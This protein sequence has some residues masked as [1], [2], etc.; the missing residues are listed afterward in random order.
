MK[1]LTG[2]QEIAKAI[3]FGKYP[4]LTIN[5]ENRPYENDLP[6]S[7]YAVG[8]RV[9]VAW[10]HK[11]KRYE[12]MTTHGNLFIE[13]GKLKISAEGGCL[14]ADFGYYDVIKM[15]SEAN[16][17]VVHKSQEVVVVEEWPSQRKARV[18]MMRVSDHIDTLC[19]VA[20][21]LDDIEDDMEKKFIIK[22]R[23]KDGTVREVTETGFTAAQTHVACI[24]DGGGYIIGIKEANE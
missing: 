23:A 11:D 12:G 22:F 7:D 19:M 21:T 13:N 9:R 10:D 16:A 17:P 18:R 6:E 1:I 20:A 3:N 2:R 24:V 4:V 5:Y 14:H 8:C 15:A